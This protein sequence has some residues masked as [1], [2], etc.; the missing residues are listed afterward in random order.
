M[1]KIYVLNINIVEYGQV[2][3]VQTSLNLVKFGP[4]EWQPLLLHKKLQTLQP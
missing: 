4:I 1:Y 3:L 2:L